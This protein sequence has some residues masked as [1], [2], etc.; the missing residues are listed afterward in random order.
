MYFYELKPVILP[1]LALFGSLAEKLGAD[2]GNPFFWLRRNLFD[3]VVERFKNRV[4]ICVKTTKMSNS[5]N[6]FSF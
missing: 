3:I 4:K 2:I 1:L 6:Y 5:Y